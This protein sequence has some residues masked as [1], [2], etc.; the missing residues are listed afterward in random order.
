MIAY[1]FFYSLWKP[2]IDVFTGFFK[3]G[4]QKQ[5]SPPVVYIIPLFLS[6]SY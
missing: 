3:G 5:E 4:Q 2:W 1:K 6:V